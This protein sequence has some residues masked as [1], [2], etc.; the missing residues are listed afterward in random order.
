[1]IGANSIGDNRQNLIGR[2]VVVGVDV[3]L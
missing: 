2:R 1:V 3:P